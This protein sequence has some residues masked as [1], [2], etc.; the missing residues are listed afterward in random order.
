VP[1]LVGAHRE[2]LQISSLKL[3]VLMVETNFN[4][5]FEVFTAVTMKNGVFWDFTRRGSCKNRRFGE[6]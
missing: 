1:K 5:T 6:T 4:E 3:Y 2:N